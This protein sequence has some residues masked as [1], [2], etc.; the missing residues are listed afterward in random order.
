MGEVKL[1]L[2][3]CFTYIFCYWVYSGDKKLQKYFRKKKEDTIKWKC[4]MM[5]H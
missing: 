3:N 4:V 5:E 1:V 2:N